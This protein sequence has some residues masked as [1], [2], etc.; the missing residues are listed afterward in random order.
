MGA[1]CLVLVF[2]CLLQP[3]H[4]LNWATSALRTH[5]LDSNYHSG[6]MWNAG[7][8]RDDRLGWISVATENNCFNDWT[9]E[10]RDATHCDN[11]KMGPW[12]SF[13]GRGRLPA[14]TEFISNGSRWEY[15]T[16]S[17]QPFILSGDN[18]YYVVE[19]ARLGVLHYHQILNVSYSIQALLQQ[20]DCRR[21]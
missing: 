4:S 9:N 12:V 2:S 8:I 7:A 10:Y 16:S 15:D 11:T 21:L 3:A 1:G 17:I 5:R 19:D 18:P 20:R 13:M 6:I 14:L